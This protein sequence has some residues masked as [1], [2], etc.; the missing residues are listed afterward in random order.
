MAAFRSETAQMEQE[1]ASA[2][3]EKKTEKPLT[4]EKIFPKTDRRDTEPDSDFKN[5]ETSLESANDRIAALR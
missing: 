4:V 5:D 2:T 3:E 1:L